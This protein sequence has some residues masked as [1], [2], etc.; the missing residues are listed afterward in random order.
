MKILWPHSQLC[1]SIN[2]KLT[3]KETDTDGCWN[4]EPARGQTKAELL[5]VEGEGGRPMEEEV[6]GGPLPTVRTPESRTTASP[7]CCGSW[8]GAAARMAATQWRRQGR[9]PAAACSPGRNHVTKD[10]RYGTSLQE[11]K[12]SGHMMSH[13]VNTEEH[14]GN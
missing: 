13:V 14:S 12:D 5:K 11:T 1:L 10:S 7:G 9:H 3:A 4:C 6:I 2:S 8:N